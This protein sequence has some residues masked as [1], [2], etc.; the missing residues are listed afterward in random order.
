MTCAEIITEEEHNQGHFNNGYAIDGD[1]A[2]VVAVRLTH[3]IE[4]G[5]VKKYEIK[6]MTWLKNLPKKTCWLC[7]GTGKRKDMKVE[8]GC[9]ACSGTGKTEAEECSYPFAEENVK[10]FA[11]FCRHSGGFMIC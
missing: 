3:L 4:Q 1:R 6:Y 11:E 8:N 9:N 7:N 2:W 10:E 5:E